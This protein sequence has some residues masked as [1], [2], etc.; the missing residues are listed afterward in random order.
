MKA[1]FCT[2][3]FTNIEED[4]KNSHKPNAVSGHK[5]QM[6]LLRGIVNNGCDIS[7]V[8]VPNIR[9]WPDYPKLFL[10][11]QDFC[12]DR[13]KLGVTVGRLNISPFHFVWSGITVFFEIVKI[14]RENKD[15]NQKI[16]LAVYNSSL[17]MFFSMW[18][19]QC[20]FRNVFL[21]DIIGDFH[22]KNGIGNLGTGLPGWITKVKG[23]IEDWFARKSNMY[24]LVTEAQRELLPQNKP[25]TVVEGVYTVSKTEE[26]TSEHLTEENIEKIVFYAGSLRKDYGIMHLLRAFSQIQSSQYRLV[27]AGANA[28]EKALEY[29]Q[30][31][32]RISFL[33]TITPEEVKKWQ[34]RAT[35]LISPRTSENSFVKYSFPSKTLECLAAG[36]PYIAHRLPCDPPEYASYIQ[37]ARD[38]S[39][40]ALRD[41]IVEIC[42][43]PEERRREIGKRAQN[44]IINEKNPKI[45]CKRIVE[46]WECFYE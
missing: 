44:F 15:K 17:P 33:G 37:Y 12:L 30:R 27:L 3:V 35:V 19:A 34:N 9:Y 25:Y 36:K 10:K 18:I 6:N 29:A 38:E 42:E 26:T 39:D 21:C 16:I 5:F 32:E 4:M 45:M 43:L 7:V 2:R 24:V 40:E 1:V 23:R 11:K 14:I 8:N 28:D 31:D 46:M 41:K 20:M 22:G 13:K